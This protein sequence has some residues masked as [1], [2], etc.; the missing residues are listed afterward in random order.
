M[1]MIYYYFAQKYAHIVWQFKTILKIYAII[2]V[3]AMYVIC[4]QAQFISLLYAQEIIG[5]FLFIGAFIMIGWN[6]GYFSKHNILYIREIMLS[7]IVK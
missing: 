4:L 3:S 2:F 7:Y 1:S 5:K 6:K